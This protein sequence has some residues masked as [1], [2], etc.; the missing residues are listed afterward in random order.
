MV[1]L[2]GEPWWKATGDS[3]AG[4][5]EEIGRILVADAGLA[6]RLR[7]APLAKAA[8]AKK[9]GELEAELERATRMKSPKPSIPGG[10]NIRGGR[11]RG[12]RPLD[13]ALWGSCCDAAAWPELGVLPR[14]LAPALRCGRRLELALLK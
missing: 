9:R 8:A 13:P 10:V 1:N 4:M 14:V 7:P 5:V 12:G 2:F 3:F 6:T 11:L